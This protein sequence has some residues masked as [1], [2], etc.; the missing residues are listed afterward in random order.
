MNI[1]AEQLNSSNDTYAKQDLFD[2]LYKIKK[3]KDEDKS[4]KDIASILGWTESLV[5]QYSALNSK[6]TPI[7]DFCKLRQKGRVTEEVT[8]ATF[9]FT[10]Y[11]FRTSGLYDLTEEFQLLFFD[12]FKADNF[13]W[14][15]QK[16][17]QATAKYKLW[18]EMIELAKDRLESPQDII[19]LIKSGVFTTME[20]LERRIDKVLIKAK[21]KLLQ[22]NTS[23]DTLGRGEIP[24][25]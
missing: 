17:Q 16:V 13:N 18:Q 4:I 11:W 19:G 22:C 8:H 20:Q 2:V 7:L 21:S 10:E 24:H 25:V 1:A 9:D 12:K 5:K 6:V 3:M 15:K 14:N 23:V